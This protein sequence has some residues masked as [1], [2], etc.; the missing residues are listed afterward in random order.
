MRRGTG[1]GRSDHVAGHARFRWEVD[2]KTKEG[3]KCLTEHPSSA[4]QTRRLP[5]NQLKPWNIIPRQAPR[6]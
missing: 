3:R 6:P 2:A 1:C 5:T 4:E